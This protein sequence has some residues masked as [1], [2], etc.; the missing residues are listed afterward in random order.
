MH[1]REAHRLDAQKVSMKTIS[2]V[3]QHSKAKGHS[4]KQVVLQNE[5]KAQAMPAAALWAVT[6][7]PIE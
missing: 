7:M 6:A 5:T 2:T 3:Q 1:E 4:S